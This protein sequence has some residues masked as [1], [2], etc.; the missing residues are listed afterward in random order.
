VLLFLP[1]P[2][3]FNSLPMRDALDTGR[4]NAPLHLRASDHRP[5]VLVGAYRAAALG[6]T[7]L[8]REELALLILLGVVGALLVAAVRRVVDED[9][10]LCSLALSS[11]PVGICGFALFAVLFPVDALNARLQYRAMGGAAYL[12]FMRY[13][14]WLDVL[15]AAP[16]RAIYFQFAPFPLHV[17]STFDLVA[18]LSLPLLIALAVTAYRSIQAVETDSLVEILLGIVYVGGI[19]GYGLIDSNFGTTIRH[20]SVFVFLLAVFSAPILESW[21]RSLRQRVDKA[22]YQR[23]KTDENSAKLRNLTPAPRFDLNTETT[24]SPVRRR[25][26]YRATPARYPA[27]R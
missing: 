2:F 12:E 13:E 14:S 25:Q 20:R 5:S 8:L 27:A 24:L 19:V 10:S 21:Y 22:I 26:D 3:L 9:V 11:V 4:S 23:R 18:I 6:T 17:T 1:F 15:L 16:V 7:V